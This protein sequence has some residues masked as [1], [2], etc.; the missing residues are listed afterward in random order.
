MCVWGWLRLYLCAWHNWEEVKGRGSL[1][2]VGIHG[3][4]CC[5][6]LDECWG[7]DGGWL[8]GLF[9]TAVTV[10]TVDE[11]QMQHLCLELADGAQLCPPR[12]A[13]GRSPHMALQWLE[14]THCQ[15]K[16]RKTERGRLGE[17]EHACGDGMRRLSWPIR[18]GSAVSL[19]NSCC[20]HWAA[21]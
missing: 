14:E 3:N 20:Q 5:K 10:S 2:P 8:W 4:R 18:R 16:R 1:G 21:Q 15:L 19:L 13:V 17:R 11:F 12:H 9:I 7:C 6:V